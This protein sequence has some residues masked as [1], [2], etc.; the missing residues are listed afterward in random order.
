MVQLSINVLGPLQVIIDG[1]PVYGFASD[2]VRALLVYLV[3][4]P[5]QP[6][7][8]EVL[9]GLLWPE[10]PEQ[11]ARNSLRNALANLRSVIRDKDAENPLLQSTRQTI[12]FNSDSGYWLDADALGGLLDQE[13]L[14]IKQLVKAV[15]LVRGQFL[16]GFSLADA[17]PF[18]EWVLL[19]REF[20]ERLL[21][22]ALDKLA[23][24]YEIDGNYKQAL[25]YSRRLV[26]LDP[27]QE[28]WQRQLMRLLT[29]SGQRDKALIQ[30][31]ELTHSLQKE[32]RIK[33]AAETTSLY[34]EI[35]SDTLTSAPV[36][37][38][39]SQAPNWNFPTPPTPFIGRADELL[40]LEAKLAD[41]QIRLVTITGLGGSGKTRLALEFARRL[42]ERDHQALIDQSPL[43]YTHGIIYVPLAALDSAESFILALA[44]AL[45][46]RLER[47]LE[48]LLDYMQ[49]KQ[50]LLILDNMEQLLAGARYLTAI[51]Q[52]APGIK[53]LVTSRERLQLQSE[54]VLPLGGLSCP[55]DDFTTSISSKDALDACLQKYPALQLL[56]NS[57]QRVRPDFTPSSADLSSLQDICQLVD[58]LPLALELAASWAD[59]IP[60]A[61]IHLETQRSLD[62]WQVEWV[63]LPER[64]RSIRA[65]FTSSWQRLNAVEK[66][67]FSSL[68]VFRGGFTRDAARHV[69]RD[70]NANAHLLA[71][72]V[73]KSFLQYDHIGDR[74]QIHELLRQYGMEKLAVE[75][76]RVSEVCDLHSAYYTHALHKWEMD[77]KSAQ[78]QITLREMEIESENLNAAWD[79]AV[80]QAQFAR[81]GEAIGGI[82]FFY[83]LTGRYGQ[84][85]AAFSAAAMVAEK[86]LK[87]SDDQP[88]CLRMLVK[89]LTWQSFYIRASGKRDDA[90]QLQQYC[91]S[92][93]KHP[94]LQGHD[95][96][97]ERAI[98]NFTMG[99]TDCMSDYALG[100]QHFRQAYQLYCELDLEWEMASALSAWSTMSVY[101]GDYK[102]AKKCA[103]Q[104]LAIYR[105]NGNQSGIAGV[106]RRLAQI[107]WSEGRFEEAEY[108]A[109][110]GYHASLSVGTQAEQ[111][112]GL[113]C[114]G[115]T[116]E[117]HAKF[118][119]AY[120][121]AQKSLMLFSELG[122]RSY[123]T[124][125]YSFMG[126]IKL[127]MGYFEDA[128]V[129]IQKGL[130]LARDYG[131]RYCIGLNLLLLGCLGLAQ[132]DCLRALNL[133][134]ESI[135]AYGE[136]NQRD[137]ISQ[138]QACAAFAS[139]GL[140]DLNATKQHLYSAIQIVI[141]LNAVYPLLWVLPAMALFLV[142]KGECERAIELYALA[143][144]YP[145]VAKSQWFEDIAGK[146]ISA[147]A[148]SMPSEVVAA[149][150]SRGV[151][152]DPMTCIL[153][154]MKACGG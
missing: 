9:A 120:S 81:L 58:G 59:V 8:R 37:Q 11:A 151:N 72:L 24:L 21:A 6:Y 4:S 39:D 98:L 71:V 54:H 23:S 27:W 115:E 15:N 99:V 42:V 117:K 41:P 130:L 57:I 47:G 90:R 134:E 150:K 146:E 25:I 108:L 64:Q 111:A 70:V 13:L 92:L 142:N 112:F 69:V 35:F 55:Q 26:N 78:Q 7:R 89:A 138:A 74:Y 100:I 125:A 149:A 110:E 17:A 104:A 102:T 123:I 3:L 145:L 14:S 68:T 113:L 87:G 73:R 29:L 84:A 16:E 52:T 5:D 154:F 88:L 30:Y 44:S 36:Q 83:W 1:E 95:T 80:E 65:V 101:L 2:K 153:D 121:F 38:Q 152:I 124:Q 19:R 40:T 91:L 75:P 46:L 77:L 66:V 96:R 135:A 53:F 31:D 105:A 51:L 60:L 97:L 85:E 49:N 48:Q 122:H 106:L 109:R 128:R 93:L 12:Q 82:Q 132:K 76:E 148:E 140:G 131:P 67:V 133:F 10:F 137:G 127:H 33:P 32:L 103:E 22:E 147:I 107:A 43:T 143:R 119:E 18:E 129:H 45:R 141:E 144:R 136:V 86:T 28:A 50:L 114:L 56:I 34:E 118:S 94:G 126:C 139:L 116:L 20:Y 63:D 61:E 79:W 62:F